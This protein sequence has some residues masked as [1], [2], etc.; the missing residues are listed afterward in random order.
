ML[1]RSYVSAA[2]V[3][4]AGLA[5][6]PAARADDTGDKPCET[7]MCRSVRQS[8]SK[9][10]Q[11]TSDAAR[12]TKDESEK[13]WNATKKGTDRAANWTRK[14]GRKGWDKTRDGAKDAAHDAKDAAHDATDWTKKKAHDAAEWSADKTK[15]KSAGN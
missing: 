14:E 1:Y 7:D 9:V 3:L 12:W 4:V 10:R 5:Q 2:L 13:G 15:D 11:D 8:W 6:I